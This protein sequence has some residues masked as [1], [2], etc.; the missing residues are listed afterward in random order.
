MKSATVKMSRDGKIVIPKGVRDDLGWDI[1][2]E[3]MLVMTERGVLLRT[4]TQAK[5]QPVKSLR[6]FLPV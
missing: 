4:Q 5:K 2:V 1:G 6:G 3:L